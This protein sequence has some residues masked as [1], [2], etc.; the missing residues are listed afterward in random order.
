M[1]HNSLHDTYSHSFLPF[2]CYYPSH[3]KCPTVRPS[4]SPLKHQSTFQHQRCWTGCSLLLGALSPHR[5]TAN[6]LYPFKFQLNFLMTQMNHLYPPIPDLIY[7]ALL[8]SFSKHLPHCRSFTDEL[9]N[10]AFKGKNSSDICHHCRKEIFVVSDSVYCAYLFF[11]HY[12]PG[13]SEHTL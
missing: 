11:S 3:L 1:A 7:P 5:C 8:W 9:S 2:L 13:I 6:P 10:H 4:N 12:T